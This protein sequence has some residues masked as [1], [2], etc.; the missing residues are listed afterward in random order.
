ME[1]LG[2]ASLPEKDRQ[3]LLAFQVKAGE[4]QR[5][6]MGA[7]GA[8]DEALRSIQFMKKALERHAAAPTPRSASDVRAVE[9]KLRAAMKTLTG[10]AVVRRGRKPRCRRSWIASAVSSAR[11]VRS[12]PP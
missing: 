10:D 12:P 6:M 9:T 5:A 3:G 11:R 1:S 7:A 8:A 4:L 2:L